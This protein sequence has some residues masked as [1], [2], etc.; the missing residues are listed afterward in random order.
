MVGSDNP[1]EAVRGEARLVRYAIY[2]YRGLIVDEEIRIDVTGTPVLITR[3]AETAIADGLPPAVMRPPLASIL[4]GPAGP[5]WSPDL[6]VERLR[7]GLQSG[8]AIC[9]RIE[10]DIENIDMTMGWRDHVGIGFPRSDTEVIVESLPAQESRILLALAL[11]LPRNLSPHF[12]V[13]DRATIVHLPTDPRPV[14]LVSITGPTAQVWLGGRGDAL[15]RAKFQRVADPNGEKIDDL[16][17]IRTALDE[18]SQPLAGFLA[19]WAALERLLKRSYAA[20]LSAFEAAD[21]AELSPSL[22]DVRRRLAESGGKGSLI[23]QFLIC[24]WGL[25]PEG[26]QDDEAAFRRLNQQRQDIYHR[27]DISELGSARDNAV[28]LLLQLLSLRWGLQQD[29]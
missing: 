12:S 16:G 8:S 2:I 18:S 22:V 5:T 28:G 4:G 14:S 24:R 25:S 9:I 19:A 3:S 6:A 29:C 21:L 15:D 10:H 7:S 20:H 27:G 17:L 23:N 1:I 11:A 13:F 26:I